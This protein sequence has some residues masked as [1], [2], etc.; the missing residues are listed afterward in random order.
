MRARVAVRAWDLWSS[1]DRWSAGV[2]FGDP[3]GP[4]GRDPDDVRDI[5]CDLTAPGEVCSPPEPEPFVPPSGPVSTGGNTGVGFG[6]GN[7]LVILLVAAV[8][9]AIV[10]LVLRFL[11]D[12]PD[13]DG[14][15]DDDDLDSDLDE[16]LER[17]RIDH[18][19]PPD[20]WRAA[21]AEHRGAGRF[22]DAIRCEYR[23]LVGD[24][25]RAGLVDEIPGRTSGEERRQLAELAPAVA[26]DFDTAA[27]RFDE[28]W[29]SELPV[30]SA[31]DA[32]FLAA[33]E[34][35]LSAV[36]GGSRSAR[37]VGARR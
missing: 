8:V 4:V 31:E 33:A 20:R 17:R 24:L 30:G 2:R 36:F 34:A 14:D 11:R 18:A 37:V 16:L 13:D 25:A 21:A 35:V 27:D 10:L 9:A 19:R 32:D 12:R 3:L 26:A 23:A 15:E 28:A 6:F 29:F 22:R 5:A 7:L 1:W